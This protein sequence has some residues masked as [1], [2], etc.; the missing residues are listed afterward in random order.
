MYK[1][2]YTE[3]T[4][5]KASEFETKSLLYLMSMRKDSEEIDYF[6]VDCFNDVTGMN[7][8]YNKL[9]DMQSKGIKTL[10][11]KKIGESLITLFENF[12]SD[13]NFSFYLL[14][15]PKVND[16]YILDSKIQVFK[17][18]NFKQEYIQ[19][20]VEGLQQEYINRHELITQHVM[21]QIQLFIEIVNFV[22]ADED[23]CKYI[24]NLIKF[25]K[26]INKDD[27][28]FN[29]IFNEIRDKQSVLKN[30]SIHKKEITEIKEVLNFNKHIKRNEIEM[31]LIN[32]I[33]GNDIFRANNIPI[34]F[35]NELKKLN[36]DEDS[37]RDIIQQCNS[38]ISLMMFNNN[39]KKNFW[40]FFEIIYYLIRKY[41]NYTLGEIYR[42]IP[43]EKINKIKS[44]DEISI[45]FFIALL[46]EGF[47]NENS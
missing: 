19:K 35:Y 42:K 13:I 36:V 40:K 21:E 18:E 5:E 47:I 14:F 31:L 27:E 28:F 30:M 45:K 38:N 15:F 29:S 37:V 43:I 24:K 10:T 11:P 17:I 39:N 44:L 16:R 1:F 4:N 2:L 32:R 7:A 12:L 22:I 46:K 25:K 26:E 3:Q 33:I 34:S 23:K 6:L 8:N 9:W 20:I 41:P